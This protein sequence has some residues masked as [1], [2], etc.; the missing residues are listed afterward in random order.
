MGDVEPPPMQQEIRT[1]RDRIKFYSSAADACI[2]VEHIDV[3]CDGCECEPIV[4]ERYQCEECE[5]RDLCQACYTA[6]L[7]ARSTMQAAASVPA[8]YV[9]CV[10]PAPLFFISA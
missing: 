10:H 5:D 3:T 2:F 4:G 1:M 8:P 9:R 7:S 6:L